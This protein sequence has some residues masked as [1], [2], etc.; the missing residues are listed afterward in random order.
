[1]SKD[2]CDSGDIYSSATDMLTFAKWLTVPSNG[3]DATYTPFSSGQAFV[4]FSANPGARTQPWANRSS[5]RI[6]FYMYGRSFNASYVGFQLCDGTTAQVTIM[7]QSNNLVVRSGGPTGTILG[8]LAGKGIFN[9]W[10]HICLDVTIHNTTGSL[11]LYLDGANPTSGA[12]LDLTN[13]NTRGGTSNNYMNAIGFVADGTAGHFK[14]IFVW[15]DDGTAPTGWIGQPRSYTSL[16]ASAGAVT[17]FP[18]RVGG[19][20]TNWSANANAPHNGDTSY[21]SSST[22]GHVDLYGLAALP[23]TPTSI[24]GLDHFLIVRKEDAG[25]RTVAL[26]RRSSTGGVTTDL[27]S[28]ASVPVG[29]DR[30]GYWETTNPDTSTAWTPSTLPQLGPKIS[31]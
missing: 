6:S 29:Y 27:L 4:A 24:Y 7:Y 23:V 17:D 18:T 26:R 11:K 16:A 5:Q 25:P 2:F 12:N 19:S 3:M 13:V 30:L 20:G 22:A 9:I 14:D 15:N 28:S 10:H 31:V 1:M 21:V 8:T